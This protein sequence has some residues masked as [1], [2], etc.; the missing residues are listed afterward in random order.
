MG[1]RLGVFSHTMCIRLSLFMFSLLGNAAAQQIQAI[2]GNVA[3]FSHTINTPVPTPSNRGYLLPSFSAYATS[4]GQLG[5][6]QGFSSTAFTFTQPPGA[7]LPT[8]ACG[9]RDPSIINWG[10]T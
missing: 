1:L 3:P 4:S 5:L 7:T 6:Y 2:N 8:Y 10:G 9:V